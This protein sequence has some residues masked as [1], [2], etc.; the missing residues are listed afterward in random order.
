M[1]SVEPDLVIDL[2]LSGARDDEQM[3]RLQ[4]IGSEK[5]VSDESSAGGAMQRLWK[6][7][8]HS[9]A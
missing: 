8:P 1:G 9:R 6:I 4:R 7:R 3:G 5:H 2:V